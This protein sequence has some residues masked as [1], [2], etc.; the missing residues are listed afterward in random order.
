MI[1][2]NH[3]VEWWRTPLGVLGTRRKYAKYRRYF[4]P[5]LTPTLELPGLCLAS[6][7]TSHGVV[8][9]SLSWKLWRDTAVKGHLPAAEMAR[10]GEVFRRRRPGSLPILVLH[11]NLFR[12]AISRRM[13]LVRWRAAQAAA[14]SSGAELILDG[15]DHQEAV[16]LLGGQVVVATAGTHC[17]R[18][19]GGRPS[20]FNVIEVSAVAI[21]V[22]HYAWNAGRLRFVPGE[23]RQFERRASAA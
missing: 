17:S 20:A 13:G 11:H 19:R 9:G 14:A 2:G 4:G 6:V 23:S 21:A 12:G 22:R 8:V 15:H 3:D 10:V 5:D 16:N 1:P 18:I 7:L